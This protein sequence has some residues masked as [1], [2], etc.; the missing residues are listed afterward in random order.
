MNADEVV[1]WLEA[2]YPPD[3]PPG[4][5]RSHVVLWL[6]V[7]T[8]GRVTR[9]RLQQG[10][11]YPELDSLAARLAPGFAYQPALNRGRRVS[12]WVA[13]RIRFHPPGGG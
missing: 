12:V 7:D 3:L 5:A 2:E 13:Q 4:A 1:R 6:F 8:R 10:S 9:L 11:G